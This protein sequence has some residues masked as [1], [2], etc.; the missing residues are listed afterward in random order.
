MAG[1]GQGAR[2][3]LGLLGA[4]E[5]RIRGRA[6]SGRRG[7]R[8]SHA[9][10][11]GAVQGRYARRHGSP[12]EHQ[13]GRDLLPAP[14]TPRD[15]AG[16]RDGVPVRQRR[17]GGRR[18]SSLQAIELGRK[19][20]LSGTDA[21][22]WYVE[23]ATPYVPSPLL[24]GNK[25]YFCYVNQGVISCYNARTGKAYFFKKRLEEINEIYASPAGASGRVYFVGRNGVT[26]V[27]KAS[28]KYVLLA[29]NKLDDRFDCS[30]AFVGNEIFLKGKQNMYCVVN[31]GEL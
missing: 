16:E 31:S 10:A 24:Y 29:V 12:G 5:G 27:L 18:G 9:A 28:E 7:V 11:A 4:A 20:D 19:G 22:K 6:D 17:P 13:D 3:V 15:A 2:S 1:A 30:P 25:L 21:V 14:E 26:Y 8:C 23:K